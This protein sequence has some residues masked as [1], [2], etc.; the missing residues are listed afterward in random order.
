MS[1]PFESSQGQSRLFRP[2]LFPLPAATPILWFSFFPPVGQRVFLLTPVAPVPLSKKMMTGV[3]S[4]GLLANSKSP[5]AA[6]TGLPFTRMVPI[7]GIST[8]LSEPRTKEITTEA[9]SSGRVYSVAEYSPSSVLM[10]IFFDDAS[11]ATKF[12]NSWTRALLLVSVMWLSEL[13]ALSMVIKK[14]RQRTSDAN[15]L[16]TMSILAP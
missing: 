10:V 14:Q 12:F 15:V 6:V 8:S 9:L 16:G 2:G 5:V 1:L 11:D 4:S 3:C 7:R 13:R